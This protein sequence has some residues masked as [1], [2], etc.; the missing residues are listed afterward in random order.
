MEDEGTETAVL[1]PIGNGYAGSCPHMSRR[2]R[3]KL[4]AGVDRVCA[5][6]KPQ[7]ARRKGHLMSP[8]SDFYSIGLEHCVGRDGNSN[9]S[10]RA[11]AS[12]RYRHGGVGREG[13]DGALSP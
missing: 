2:G 6:M 5:I 8:L 11:S 7:S 13:F 3:T 4:R 1:V 12:G 10:R 9:N